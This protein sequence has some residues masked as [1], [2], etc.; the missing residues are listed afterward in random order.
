MLI[1]SSMRR[2]IQPCGPG[3]GLS[4]LG[5]KRG[6]RSLWHIYRIVVKDKTITEMLAMGRLVSK[7]MLLNYIKGK[8]SLNF[9]PTITDYCA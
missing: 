3:N 9:K 7:V 1:E 8:R 2:G 6:V 4:P 5:R